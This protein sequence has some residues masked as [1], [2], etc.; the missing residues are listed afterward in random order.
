METCGRNCHCTRTICCYWRSSNAAQQKNTR[1]ERTEESKIIEFE[2]Q[3]YLA[4]H[5]ILLTTWMRLGAK[6]KD[7]LTAEEMWRTVKKD[8]TLKSTL[9]SLDAEDQLTSMKLADN[10]DPKAHLTELKQ[11]QGFTSRT[12]VRVRDG[13][14]LKRLN[15]YP[16]QL[17]RLGQLRT[18]VG[19]KSLIMQDYKT[20]TSAY[21]GSGILQKP[22]EGDVSGC[23]PD[24]QCFYYF[25]FI[26]FNGSH[27]PRSYI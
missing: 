27:Y 25:P 9:F 13:S 6:I 16:A 2:K 19:S 11:C 17:P 12:P 3:E 26:W 21:H 14:L 15:E 20:T 1:Y 22:S 5:I 8:T 23:H 18:R 10:E 4:Q 7:M 24:F